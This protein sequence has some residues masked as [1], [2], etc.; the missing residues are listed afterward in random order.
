MMCKAKLCVTQCEFAARTAQLRHIE[1]TRQRTKS[2]PL[3]PKLAA[4]R[5]RLGGFKKIFKSNDTG[6]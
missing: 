2:E 3:E 5:R 4:S 1:N 6:A